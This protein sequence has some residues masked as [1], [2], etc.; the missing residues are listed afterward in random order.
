M[1]LSLL[2]AALL[3]PWGEDGSSSRTTTCLNGSG[4]TCDGEAVS[5]PHTWNADDAC[6]GPG[7]TVN[8][9]AG[10]RGGD[11]VGG[12]GYLKKRAVYARQLPAKRA[13]RRYFLKFEG[14]SVVAEVKVNGRAVGSHVGAVRPRSPRGGR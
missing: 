7:D 8:T 3:T 4:W 6:D 10:R 9:P 1:M 13:G 2:L 5:V 12:I 11:S 14:A